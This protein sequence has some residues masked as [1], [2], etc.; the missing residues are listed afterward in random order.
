[1]WR[2]NFSDIIKLIN[3][4]TL[5]LYDHYCIM[6]VF[7]WRNSYWVLLLIPLIYWLSKQTF[8]SLNFRFHIYKMQNFLSDW[9]FAYFFF[10]CGFWVFLILVP[11]YV[12]TKGHYNSWSPSLHVESDFFIINPG[13]GC[14]HLC[15]L[16]WL[17]KL[18]STCSI[19]QT[20]VSTACSINQKLHNMITPMKPKN[21]TEPR[22]QC[23]GPHGD[24]HGPHPGHWCVIVRFADAMYPEKISCVPGQ[25]SGVEE[26][27]DHNVTVGIVYH[28]LS[29]ATKKNN[30]QC[31]QNGLH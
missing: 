4:W 26:L 19:C 11:P 30:E 16:Y 28:V 7:P 21:K 17:C 2:Y 18:V 12:K 3:S 25:S 31:W 22:F 23:W 13:S 24:I 27:N 29:M 10:F 8:I 15:R 20:Y 9:N 1:M 5:N 6:N 14:V